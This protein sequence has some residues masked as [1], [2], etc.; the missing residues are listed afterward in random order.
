MEIKEFMVQVAEDFW[1][2]SGLHVRYFTGPSCFMYCVTRTEGLRWQPARHSEWK[3]VQCRRNLI[4]DR[5][6]HSR[7]KATSWEAPIFPE[8]H[9]F[10]PDEHTLTCDMSRLP[11]RQLSL[12]LAFKSI[13]VQTSRSW[14][15]TGS[16]SPFGSS[17]NKGKQKKYIFASASSTSNTF[18]QHSLGFQRYQSFDWDWK[19]LYLANYKKVNWMNHVA[20]KRK[21]P[22]NAYKTKCW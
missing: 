14:N 12:V 7:S 8:S 2:P 9:I 16:R 17:L 1:G 18:R 6:I 22:M 15:E 4:S 20:K 13:E 21:G 5:H 11:L 10:L 19:A 3:K